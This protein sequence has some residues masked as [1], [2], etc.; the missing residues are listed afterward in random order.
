M[1]WS[2][3]SPPGAG[4]RELVARG[5]L[6]AYAVIAPSLAASLD[7]A[8]RR[9][10][11]HVKHT[12][13]PVRAAT[14]PFLDRIE[15]IDGLTFGP[16]GLA[17]PR[18]ALYDCACLPG[19]IF[20]LGRAARE[21]DAATRSALGAA[22]GED[23]GELVPLSLLVAIPMLGDDRWL[24]YSLATAPLRDPIPDLDLATLVLGLDLL[25]AREVTA[26]A[27]W[28]SPELAT[29]AR[30]APIHVRAAWLPAHDIPASAVLSI[31]LGARSL[32]AREEPRGQPPR[33]PV[34]RFFVDTR[35]DAALRAL[36]ADIE[37]GRHIELAGPPI[38]DGP[39]LRAPLL[40][41][42]EA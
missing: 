4:A 14:A 40:R 15:R 13:D 25:R 10:P 34:E 3:G 32:G 31:D 23:D 19:V 8:R 1:A 30:L 6:D 11:V 7:L 26:T 39:H 42:V 9:D 35:D 29:I 21:L 5:D 37:A 17:T 24:A 20:G 22:A 18:W 36:Q 2:D 38:Q 41:E 33:R 27:Q 28:G 12:F 16:R